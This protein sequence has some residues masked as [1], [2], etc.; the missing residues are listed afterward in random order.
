[1]P[2]GLRACYGPKNQGS[3]DQA[4]RSG[5]RGPKNRT[6]KLK[7]RGAYVCDGR[8]YEY[9]EYDEGHRVDAEYFRNCAWCGIEIDLCLDCRDRKFTC[10]RCFSE[11]GQY[12]LEDARRRA[13]ARERDRERKRH[14]RKRPMRIPRIQRTL[15]TRRQVL[16][17]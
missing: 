9:D 15:W 12:G 6:G 8:H 7:T 17:M 5:E 10:D 13:R 11:K 3:I 14:E 1:M 4:Y 2:E 16:G